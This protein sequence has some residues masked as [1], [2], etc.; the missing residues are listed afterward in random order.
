MVGTYLKYMSTTLTLKKILVGGALVL[1]CL[2]STFTLSLP[3]VEAADISPSCADRA[4]GFIPLACVDNTVLG[5]LYATGDVAPDAE[6]SGNLTDYVGRIFFFAITIGGVLAV[7]R[8][9]WAGFLY[10]TS[11]LWHT[12]ERAKE[13]LRET[14]LGLCLLLS[15]WLILNQINP[16]ILSLDFN[17]TPP[18]EDVGADDPDSPGPATPQPTQAQMRVMQTLGTYRSSWNLSPLPAQSCA[19]PTSLSMG[20]YLCFES[21]HHCEAV[22]EVEGASCTFTPTAEIPSPFFDPTLGPNGGYWR[23]TIVIWNG[24]RYHS[25]ED[26]L[27]ARPQYNECE[28]VAY[29]APIGTYYPNAETP[30]GWCYLDTWLPDGKYCDPSWTEDACRAAG[31]A[32][33]SNIGSRCDESGTENSYVSTYTEIQNDSLTSG[34]PRYCILE[35]GAYRCF[36]SSESCNE[37]GDDCYRIGNWEVKLNGVTAILDTRGTVNRFQTAALSWEPSVGADPSVIEDA[38]ESFRNYCETR[39]S[40][41]YVA[42][43]GNETRDFC[44]VSIPGPNTENF[45]TSWNAVP[46]NKW[47]YNPVGTEF[48]CPGNENACIAAVA[49]IGYTDVSCEY[50]PAR[51]TITQP[52][53]VCGQGGPNQFYC[54][55]KN[56]AACAAYDTPPLSNCALI[57][58]IPDPTYTYAP[59]NPNQTDPPQ[60]N[61]PEEVGA[62]PAVTYDSNVIHDTPILGYTCYLL[63]TS[64]YQCYRGG[65]I[66]NPPPHSQ[67]FSPGPLTGYYCFSMNNT[68]SPYYSCYTGAIT[69]AQAAQ[70]VGKTCALASLLRE[71][72]PT[73]QWSQSP[74]LEQYCFA[75]NEGGYGCVANEAAC[76]TFAVREGKT[77]TLAT[78]RNQNGSTVSTPASQPGVGLPPPT[79]TGATSVIPSAETPTETLDELP[80]K[81]NVSLWGRAIQR[82]FELWELLR[83]PSEWTA[84]FRQMVE[85]FLGREE[86]TTIEAE[87]VNPPAEQPVAQISTPPNTPVAQTYP[88]FQLPAGQWCH[89]VE[90][91]NPRAYQCSGVRAACE[92]GGQT[93]FR[94][95][96]A[97]TIRSASGGSVSSAIAAGGGYCTVLTR[98]VSNAMYCG[99]ASA[100]S[101]TEFVLNSSSQTQTT[102]SCDTYCPAELQAGAASQGATYQC[103]ITVGSWC[104]EISK[105]TSATTF[106][107][108]YHCAVNENI[109]NTARSANNPAPIN[110]STC[111]QFGPYGPTLTS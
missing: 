10:I 45:Y 69:C 71:P 16:R 38:R 20:N 19:S 96:A 82:L 76:N 23:P 30:P 11:D 35:S 99:F 57:P 83:H 7:L 52:G 103:N 73:L 26:C 32:Y 89:R 58:E 60:T 4:D 24:D 61:T 85:G 98:G 70:A 53:F 39:A 62:D 92:E 6:F 43:E 14:V 1:P 111:L 78:L 81:D 107:R 106:G 42:A 17:F 51:S 104:Y 65:P 105:P 108:R 5:D 90:G 54:G 31:N 3:S 2:I 46:E 93:C 94:A 87:V 74:R 18:A 12:K 97:S 95:D 9:A 55:F 40:A 37:A 91:S 68:S 67:A 63:S 27:A 47:C 72:G 59:A 75:A 77:C 110:N 86:E 21:W 48:Y 101:C 34:A 66:A 56:V 33:G 36:L 64:R 80:P 41:T 84:E 22:A 8:V 79:R 49:E 29:D 102:T 88:Y 25:E 50:K 28:S 44:P 100:E 13:M 109:C 15:V